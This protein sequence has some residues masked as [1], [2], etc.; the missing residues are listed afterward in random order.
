MKALAAGGTPAFMAPEMF[1]VGKTMI[2]KQKVNS[3][4]VGDIHYMSHRRNLN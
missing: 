1:H 3:P 4:K 2:E